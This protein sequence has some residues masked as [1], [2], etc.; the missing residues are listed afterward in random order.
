MDI[1]S[2]WDFFQLQSPQKINI[3]S[4]TITQICKMLFHETPEWFTELE[5]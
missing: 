4:V 1:E 5:K 2:L 3:Q